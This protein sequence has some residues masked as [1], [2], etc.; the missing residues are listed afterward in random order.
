MNGAML[1]TPDAPWGREY[2]SET[3]MRQEE[4][5]RHCFQLVYILSTLDAVPSLYGGA[6]GYL[7]LALRAPITRSRA[8]QSHR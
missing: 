2:Q 7:F 1:P 6:P 4:T 5:Q 3:A 8:R